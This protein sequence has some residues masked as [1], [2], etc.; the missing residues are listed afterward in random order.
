[1]QARLPKVVDPTAQQH[2]IHLAA[3]II[4]R[5]WAFL[6]TVAKATMVQ[7]NTDSSSETQARRIYA[8]NACFSPR[9]RIHLF[10]SCCVRWHQTICNYLGHIPEIGNIAPANRSFSAVCL[11][12]I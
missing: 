7:A 6:A 5:P 4:E 11:F 2:I 8:T 10:A 3:S 9:S 1:M 12:E